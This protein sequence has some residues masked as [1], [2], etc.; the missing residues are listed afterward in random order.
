MEHDPELAERVG[1]CLYGWK[2]KLRFRLA[3]TIF[4]LVKKRLDR[5]DSYNLYD[6]LSSAAMAALCMI[7]EKCKGTDLA[8]ESGWFKA[9]A[10][11]MGK[12]IDARIKELDG[13]DNDATEL[14]RIKND[15]KRAHKYPQI[16]ER[17][18]AEKPISIKPAKSPGEINFVLLGMLID[19]DACL[20][21]RTRMECGSQEA[22][23]AQLGITRDAVRAGLA[24]FIEQIDD[25]YKRFCDGKATTPRSQMVSVSRYLERNYRAQLKPWTE[26]RLHKV[27]E[28]IQRQSA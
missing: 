3:T 12:A 18:G 4:K 9:T 26:K 16:K 28:S 15:R 13:N 14:R 8:I 19:P 27:W 2:P 5:I 17:G 20:I 11:E 22:T 1:Y 25:L 6:D 7:V 24:S 10:K 23:A 21:I